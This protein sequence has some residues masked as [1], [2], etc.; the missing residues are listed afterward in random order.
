MSTAIPPGASRAGFA[1][2]PAM[3]PGQPPSGQPPASVTPATPAVPASSAPAPPAQPKATQ[4]DASPAAPKAQ[5]IT[6]VQF[7]ERPTRETSVGD[8]LLG[9]VG[10]VG[11]VLLAALVVGIVAG[12]LFIAV[13]RLLP[14][15]TFNGQ[16]A[17]EAALKLNALE[18]SAVEPNVSRRA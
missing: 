13:K 11:I 3:V 12:G 8:I 15:N 1:Y 9:S 10:F 6:V 16:N 14:G 7:V 2:N 4:P 5:A 18:E 17:D